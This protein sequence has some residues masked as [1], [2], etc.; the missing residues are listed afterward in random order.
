[1]FRKSNHSTEETAPTAE[2]T[3]AQQDE[4]LFRSIE[5]FRR[6]KR[7]LR[8]TIYKKYGTVN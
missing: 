3:A 4:A 5:I 2:A 6:K 1:M 7:Y 8:G